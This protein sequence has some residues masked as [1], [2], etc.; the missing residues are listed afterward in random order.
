MSATAAPTAHSGEP[1]MHRLAADLLT[2][3]TSATV[4]VAIVLCLGSVMARPLAQQ[5]DR[6]QQDSRP[7][8][9]APLRA[10]SESSVEG[11]A[12]LCTDELGVQPTLKVRGLQE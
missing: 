4:M 9:E 12:R 2:T 10:L 5:G 11:V 7:C 6:S 1:R 3:A 8:V